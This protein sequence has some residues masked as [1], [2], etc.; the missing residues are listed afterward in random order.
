M[1]G[2][3]CLG[4]ATHV[5]S[6]PYRASTGNAQSTPNIIEDQMLPGPQHRLGPLSQPAG[7][8]SRLLLASNALGIS[9]P[10]H[11]N[12]GHDLLAVGSQMTD[13][14]QN[15]LCVETLDPG[16]RNFGIAPVRILDTALGAK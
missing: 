16:L 11:S 10:V 8:V 3:E 9:V 5:S 1:K 15:H 2:F 7:Q 13:I 6:A 12:G 14:S 4:H